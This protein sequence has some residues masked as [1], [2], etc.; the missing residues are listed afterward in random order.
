MPGGK[1]R[2]YM[3]KQ[4]CGWKLQVCLSVYDVL[5]PTDVKMGWKG[6]KLRIKI[7]ISYK[8]DLLELAFL[9]KA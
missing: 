3:L 1:E 5:V 2:I 9:L 6:A 4:S 7:K 8:Y